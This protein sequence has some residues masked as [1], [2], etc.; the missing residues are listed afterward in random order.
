VIDIVKAAA[1]A[2]NQTI[3][4]GLVRMLTK[5]STQAERGHEVSKPAADSALREQ[6]QSLLSEWQLADPNPESY[7]HMLQYLSTTAPAGSRHEQAA[8][9][10]N[11]LRLVQMSLEVGTW[12]PLVDRSITTCLKEG[13][14]ATLVTMLREA[15]AES[16]V[17]A[18]R[19][20]DSL[21]QPV[22]IA[23]IASREPL[24]E[25]TL[26]YLMPWLSTEGYAALL[27]VLG[28]SQS[29]VTRRKLLDRLSRTSLDVIELVAGRLKDGRWY[30]QRNMLLLLARLGSAP[31]GFQVA[32][33]VGHIDPRVRVEALRLQLELPGQ[34]EAALRTALRDSDPR[35]VRVGVAAAQQECPPRVLPFLIELVQGTRLQDDLR[36]LAVQA[37]GRSRERAALDALLAFVDGG[38]NMFGRRRLPAK[39]PML[40]A[41][42][43][44]LS[45]AWRSEPD[46]APLLALAAASPDEDVRGAVK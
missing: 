39:S 27:D 31:E 14:A 20:R 23:S 33:W 11:T 16:G 40:V 17:S 19:L 28:S 34:R 43:R 41:A 12:G 10:L 7:R 32:P 13:G 15:P 46:A 35:V 1:D 30:V 24:D 22:A 8:E 44:V 29:R 25:A 38:K 36:L 37:L 6:V 5:L 2:N 21:T 18:E 26:D 42:L 9:P 45:A 3:S 4:H